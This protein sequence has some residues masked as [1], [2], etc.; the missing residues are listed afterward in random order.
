LIPY[1]K[2]Q[3]TPEDEEAVLAVLRSDRLTQGP[4]VREFE[5]AFAEKVGARYCVAVS[6]GTAALHLAYLA[7][8]VGPGKTVLT[9]PIS[10]VATANAVLYCRAEVKF[11]DVNPQTGLLEQVPDG[12]NY[13]VPVTLGGQWPHQLNGEIQ[14]WHIIDQCHG[15]FEFFE[16]LPNHHAACFSFHPCKH[17]AA[18]EGGAV[19][20]NDAYVADDIREMRDHG[21]SNF[22]KVMTFLGYNYRLSDI[23]AALVL[24]QL[25]RLDWNIERRREL[26]ARYDEAFQGRVETVPH[27][28][29]SARHLYQIL[30]AARNG[31]RDKLAYRGVGTQVHY[32]PIIPLQPYYQERF[33]YKRREFP[34]A[35]SYAARTLSIPL[36]PT[37]TE[38]EQDYVIEQVL[39]VVHDQVP[40]G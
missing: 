30:H 9:S 23:A 6:S 35:E 22:T 14:S 3:I 12:M 10:F 39:E 33:G 2:H 5:V 19:V 13:V 20:T 17:I 36:Y 18:G 27:S 29:R 16:E 8:G 4:K 26:A 34:N 28:E 32:K 24:S 37:L 21:R 15:P 1:A 31:I 11:T 38:S 7:C 25:K 40:V